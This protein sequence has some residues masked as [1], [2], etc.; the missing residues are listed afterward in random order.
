MVKHQVVY[1]E[2]R[3]EPVRCTVTTAHKDGSFTVRALFFV[4]PSDGREVGGYLGFVYRQVPAGKL[5]T[6]EQMGFSR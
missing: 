5:M 6:G 4:Q 1:Y 2:T 3:G